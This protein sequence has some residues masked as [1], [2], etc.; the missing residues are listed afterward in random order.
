[1]RRGQHHLRIFFH[2]FGDGTHGLDKQ[3]HFFFRFAFGGFDHHRP[4]YDQRKR[5]S[6]GMEAIIDQAFGNVHGADAFLGLQ[7][8]AEN[9][10]VHAGGR[11]RQVVR[12]FQSLADV[13]GVEHGVFGRLPQTV[14]AVSEDVCQGANEHAKISVEGAHP[15]YRLGPLVF[16]SQSSIRFRNQHR[17]GQERFK[18]L[19]HCHWA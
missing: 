18:E 7:L 19:L 4:G 1:M 12:P 17:F 14:R 13:V 3:I 8:V 6:V 11:V 9:Y 10:L 16:K 2:L 5:R 15:A